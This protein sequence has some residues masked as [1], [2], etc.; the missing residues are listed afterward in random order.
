MTKDRKSVVNVD[1]FDEIKV[2]ENDIHGYI[3]AKSSDSR[4]VLGEYAP[5]RANEVF[6]EMLKQVFSPDTLIFENFNSEDIKNI[7][8]LKQLG[9]MVA[10]TDD[11]PRI[12]VI[13]RKVYYMPKE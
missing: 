5:N 11:I 10:K 9:A 12:D 4:F 2:T 7:D 6:E 8:S 3:M 1:R 13:E